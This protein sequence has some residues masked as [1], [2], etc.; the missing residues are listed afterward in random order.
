MRVGV[1]EKVFKVTRQRSTSR[2][3]IGVARP[4]GAGA[5]PGLELK[6]FGGGAECKLTVCILNVTHLKAKSC[7]ENIRAGE[8][9]K[10]HAILQH[11]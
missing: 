11:L 3:Y 4:E 7:R 10:V 6:K 5:P 1:D 9:T 8:L 2:S